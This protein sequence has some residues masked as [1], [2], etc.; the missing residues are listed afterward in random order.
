MD[1]KELGNLGER[2]AC[3]YLV[4][5]GYKIL[6]KN[7]RINLGE[8]DIIAKKKWSFKK[9]LQNKNNKTIHFVEVKTSQ[10]FQHNR[11]GRA[12]EFSPEQRA[13]YKKQRKLIQLSRIWLEKNKI[14]QNFPWQ[15]DIIGILIDETARKAKVHYFQNAVKDY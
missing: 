9:A 6:G 5:K 4:K 15:I 13:D 2:I 11:A 12:E 14:P 3:E 8:I 10:S 1:T 7:Y